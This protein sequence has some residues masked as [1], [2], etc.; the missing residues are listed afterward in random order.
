MISFLHSASNIYT[1]NMSMKKRKIIRK[2]GICVSVVS[3][4]LCVMIGIGSKGN[5]CVSVDACMC[6]CVCVYLW[7]TNCT[8]TPSQNTQQR[9]Q[10]EWAS[11]KI[12]FPNLRSFTACISQMYIWLWQWYKYTSEFMLCFKW[13]Q[14]CA[15]TNTQLHLYNHRQKDA[16][17]T[18]ER[19]GIFIYFGQNI[20]HH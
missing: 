9:H 8:P 20:W 11:I 13:S 2:T 4:V 6:V 5:V 12:Y 17:F 15:H 18:L 14:T 1:I 7:H 3:F 19:K 16:V 10:S